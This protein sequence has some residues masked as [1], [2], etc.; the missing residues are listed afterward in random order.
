MI[1]TKKMD[2]IMGY[3]EYRYD[4][5][6]SPLDGDISE[7]DRECMFESDTFSTLNELL[8]KLSPKVLDKVKDVFGADKVWVSC[9]SF[10]GKSEDGDTS[11]EIAVFEDNSVRGFVA[12]KIENEDITNRALLNIKKMKALIDNTLDEHPVNY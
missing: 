4:Y 9:I 5:K 7:D 3:I 8:E 6:Y 1:V 12:T 11:S 10:K 2:K